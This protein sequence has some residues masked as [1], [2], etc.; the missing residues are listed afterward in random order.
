MA[1]RYKGVMRFL[2]LTQVERTGR[3]YR[4]T[5]QVCA[6]PPFTKALDLL[7]VI[8]TGSRTCGRSILLLHFAYDLLG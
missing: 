2:C 7:L 8:T 6:G 1:G 3:K 4:A 5:S